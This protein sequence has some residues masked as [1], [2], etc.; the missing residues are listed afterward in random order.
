MATVTIRADASISL[1]SGHVM[2]CL[3]LADA[4]REGGAAVL[5]VSRE[6]AGNLCGFIEA[7]G[8]RVG[9]LG[10][11]KR[12]TWQQD[13]ADTRAA[14]ASNGGNADWLVVDHY[15]L[16]RKWESALRGSARHVLA[17]DDLAD[18]PHDC[19]LL[20][21]Q[22]YANPRHARYRAL[23]PAAARLLLGPDYAMVRPEF[24]AHREAS[25]ARRK[26]DLR[27]LLVSMGG[28]DPENETA[29]VLAGLA[30]AA[31]KVGVDVVVGEGNP[32]KDEIRGLCDSL[33]G[34]TLHVQTARMAD[35]MASADLGVHGGGST[36]WERCVVG[37]PAI[38]AV[39]SEDQ[40]DIAGAIEQAGGHRVLGWGRD[41]KAQDYTHAID[42]LGPETLLGM[43]K[44]SAGLC[45]GRGSGR[46]A[47]RLLN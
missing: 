34:A 13:A 45:D 17:I 43:S 6:D 32:H 8:F 16:D 29:K 20:L 33:S 4:L 46:V 19:D 39:Q 31:R 15:A 44:I 21:D 11:S 37:L 5:F 2:R 3:T 10:A 26:G 41:L 40:A 27:R 30:K 36:T 14:I 7:R 38:V 23:V 18:R 1:G 12:V 22:N 47:A 25:L 28:T 24:L 42:M 35:L 9:R